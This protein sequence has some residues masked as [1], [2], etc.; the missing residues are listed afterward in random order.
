MYV[1]ILS[2]EIVLNYTK[3]K[4]CNWNM[5][6]KAGLA[7][8]ELQLN[9]LYLNLSSTCIKILVWKWLLLKS[10]EKKNINLTNWKMFNSSIRMHNNVSWKIMLNQK[11]KYDILVEIIFDTKKE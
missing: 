7:Q 2:S 9:L 5:S 8:V 10:S 3:S 1:N 6:I 11:E 4:G